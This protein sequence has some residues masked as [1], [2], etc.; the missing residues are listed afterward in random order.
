MFF[1]VSSAY[2]LF[3][4]RKKEAGFVLAEPFATDEWKEF[5]CLHKYS[6]WC[7]KKCEALF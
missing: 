6:C 4:K 5:Y 2:A 7:L 1:F 3:E